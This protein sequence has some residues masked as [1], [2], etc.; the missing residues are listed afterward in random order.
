M[1][2]EFG[3]WQPIATA[4]VDTPILVC[5][6]GGWPD[7]VVLRELG[8]MRV[9]IDADD[10]QISFDKWPL[11]HWMPL[12]ADPEVDG[13]DEGMECR[14]GG[15]QGVMRIQMPENCTCHMGNPPCA[16]CQRVGLECD[17]C[18]FVIPWAPG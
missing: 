18:H 13:C 14:R 10:G 11:T 12:P 2:P 3:K 4:P 7:T 9:I 5:V 1:T 17:K 16:T 15:C 6:A 8:N